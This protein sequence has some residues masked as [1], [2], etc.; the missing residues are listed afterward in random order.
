MISGTN[1]I[2]DAQPSVELDVTAK[3]NKIKATIRAHER[4]KEE[5]GEISIPV[6]MLMPNK[7]RVFHFAASGSG[8]SVVF[9]I[10]D[11]MMKTQARA[12]G[13]AVIATNQNTQW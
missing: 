9:A 13:T 2:A 5:C 1:T 8:L 12:T 11:G 7:S 10:R 6:K 4:C 3:M